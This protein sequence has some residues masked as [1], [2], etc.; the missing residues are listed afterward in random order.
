MTQQQAG[1]LHQMILTVLGTPA[2]QGSKRHVGRGVMI[3]SSKL[4]GDWRSDVRLQALAIAKRYEYVAFGEHVPVSAEIWFY[5]RRP[6]S[7]PKRNYYPTRKPDSDK[8]ER[9]TLDALTSSGLIA[10]DAQIVDCHCHK[11]YALPGEPT[12]ALIMLRLAAVDDYR[13]PEI[14]WR[15]PVLD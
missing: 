8:L 13:S 1:T 9:A 10:D 11:R 2:P 12:G 6:V 5:L 15:A 14:L 7:L 3:E 4:V